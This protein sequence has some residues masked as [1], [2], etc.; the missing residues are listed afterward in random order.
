M[1]CS[2]IRWIGSTEQDTWCALASLRWTQTLGVFSHEGRDL[3][4]HVPVNRSNTPGMGVPLAEDACTIPTRYSLPAGYGNRQVANT[5]LELCERP[6]SKEHPYLEYYYDS[7]EHDLLGHVL[8][9]LKAP[10]RTCHS[11]CAAENIP[12]S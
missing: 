10:S 7:R 12:C 6:P 2:C 8:H 1:S 5:Q 9:D 11:L 4:S 3:V